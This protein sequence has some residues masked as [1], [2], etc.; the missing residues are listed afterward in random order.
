MGWMRD[1]VQAFCDA[2]TGSLAV[3]ANR[4][5]H[6]GPLRVLDEAD[7][8]CEAS[9]LSDLL[10]TPN[11]VASAGIVLVNLMRSPSE[12]AAIAF[13][14]AN[15]ACPLQAPSRS[16][17]Q[18]SWK[19]PDDFVGMFPELAGPHRGSSQM[20][21][22]LHILLGELAQREADPQGRSRPI[23]PLW[24]V[25]FDWRFALFQ[26]S[27]WFTPHRSSPYAR[28]ARIHVVRVWR[29]ERAEDS[30]ALQAVEEPPAGEHD[31]G[32]STR[33]QAQG[34]WVEKL[35]AV[36][37]RL[38][39]HFDRF[40]ADSGRKERSILS[41]EL[42]GGA[43]RRIFLAGGLARA[44]SALCA[45]DAENLKDAT[46]ALERQCEAYRRRAGEAKKL[47]YTAPLG[48]EPL[49]GAL[50][51]LAS[52]VAKKAWSEAQSLGEDL[53]GVFE[54][55]YLEDAKS[56]RVAGEADGARPAGAAPHDQPPGRPIDELRKA[57]E[58]TQ[59]L[60]GA[61]AEAAWTKFIKRADADAKWIRSPMAQL[62]NELT[63]SSEQLDGLIDQLRQNSAP[64]RACELS[65]VLERIRRSHGYR[66]S[67]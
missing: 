40:T 14:P 43:S 8:P 18:S 11:V 50:A 26:H 3:P 9:P 47:N 57:L 66:T 51:A 63:A 54:E 44:L 37:A 65:E 2:Q 49:R 29:G 64:P 61:K 6:V 36:E 12:C 24:I 25:L 35:Q 62:L 5:E 31:P 1:V 7:A 21:L 38:D 13:A 52:Q 4:F 45:G 41:G 32:I 15:C 23:Q 53:L 60:N 10:L 22:A 17:A 55:A 28:R 19:E 42:R 33:R 20:E 16:P 34:A 67:P 58:D 59:N 27:G 56:S 30:E 39:R 46:D 48:T